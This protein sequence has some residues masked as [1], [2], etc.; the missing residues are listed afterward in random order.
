MAFEQGDVVEV[1][2][3]PT[4]GHEPKKNRPALVVSSNDFNNSTSMTIV[5]P[6]TSTDNGF[7]LH[8]PIPLKHGVYGFIEMEQLR[9]IDLAARKAIHIDHLNEKEM[10]PI[11]TCLKSF[12]DF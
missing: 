11:L 4:L 2:F 12:F 7:F 9:A 3:D 8:E 6:I 5:C 1:N 10:V